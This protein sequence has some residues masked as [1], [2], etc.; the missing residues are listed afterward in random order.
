MAYFD[1]E[2]ALY[3]AI[4][5]FSTTGQVVNFFSSVTLDAIDYDANSYSVGFI[6]GQCQAFLTTSEEFIWFIEERDIVYKTPESPVGTLPVSFGP[7]KVYPAK[8]NGLRLP[9]IGNSYYGKTTVTV[10]WR[11]ELIRYGN[12][13]VYY[14]L[15]SGNF[16]PGFGELILSD[17]T[18]P[19]KNAVIQTNNLGLPNLTFPSGS[20]DNGLTGPLGRLMSIASYVN[21]ELAAKY[22]AS[23]SKKKKK[24]LNEQTYQETPEYPPYTPYEDPNGY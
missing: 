7:K 11:D 19:L 12:L 4:G 20:R 8:V 24:S 23:T 10:R 18:R 15:Q 22:D 21:P 17:L 16:R 2:N 14:D 9:L 3:S 13:G 1:A 5:C 6:P